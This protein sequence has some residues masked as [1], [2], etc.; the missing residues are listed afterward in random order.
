[1][2][3][4]CKYGWRHLRIGGTPLESSDCHIFVIMAVMPLFSADRYLELC[5]ENAN[6]LK[7]L[8]FMLCCAEVKRSRDV[9]DLAFRVA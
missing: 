3:K 8:G 4:I 7:V 5:T 6:L 9:V 2:F 1:V